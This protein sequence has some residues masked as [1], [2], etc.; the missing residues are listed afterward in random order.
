M[1]IILDLIVLAIIVITVLMS[2]KRGFVRTLIEL[3]GFIAAVFISFTIST[4]LA[5]STYDKIIEPSI[6]STVTSTVD[7]AADNSAAA[8]VD[9]FWNEIP[10]WIKGG[11][12][13][14]GISKESLDGSITAN[15]GNGV[16]SAVESASQN[17]I[18]PAVTSTL[19]LIYQV[20][21]LIVLMALVKPLAK[22]INKLFSFS[23]IGTA[24]RV[25]G[26]VVG[27][28]KG[29]IYA[30]AFCLLITLAVSFTANGFLIF[31]GETME[32]SLF[33]SFVNSLRII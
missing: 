23:V 29:I 8:A 15:I 16:Q 19:A 1:S 7:T 3:L 12:E 22:L 32:K 4:P 33:F 6:L 28:P 14:A 31:T 30:V 24:N 20:I 25:L 17:V 5:N 2:A 10:G 21:S 13:K 9:S 26:G 11:I 18:K 27:V